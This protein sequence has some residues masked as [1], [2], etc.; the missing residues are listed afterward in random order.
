MGLHALQ[1]M[2]KEAFAGEINGTRRC[3]DAALDATSRPEGMSHCAP[4]MLR[5]G[6]KGAGAILAD[7]KTWRDPDDLEIHD[8]LL[9]GCAAN[10]VAVAGR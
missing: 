7:Y 6:T 5:I 10:V 9:V 1:S 4:R 3:D 8:T 2:T